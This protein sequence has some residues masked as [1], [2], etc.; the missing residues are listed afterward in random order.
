[1]SYHTDPHS[2]I[3]DKAYKLEQSLRE[4]IPFRYI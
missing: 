4:K 3:F 1:L 2:N